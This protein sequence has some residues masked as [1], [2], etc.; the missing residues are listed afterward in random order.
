MPLFRNQAYI[1]NMVQGKR[2]VSSFKTKKRLDISPDDWVIV[3]NTHEPIIDNFSWESVQ[4]R[5]EATRK[6]PSNHTIKTNSTEEVNVFSG[7]IRC[8]DCG[9]MM[10]FNRKERV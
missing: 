6:A 2:K 8:A 7:I 9:S 3:G 10:A 4:H 1:G 5:L